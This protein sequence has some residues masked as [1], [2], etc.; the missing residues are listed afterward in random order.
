[1]AYVVLTEKDLLALV[2][3][4][5]SRA[6]RLAAALSEMEDRGLALTAVDRPSHEAACYIFSGAERAG[7]L[8]NI[9]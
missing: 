8:G 1:M 2:E 9:R 5:G 6:E 3:D 4:T 7:R